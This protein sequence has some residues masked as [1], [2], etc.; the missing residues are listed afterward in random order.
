MDNN[1]NESIEVNEDNAPAVRPSA[2]SDALICIAAVLI[3]SFWSYE[4]YM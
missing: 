2:V 3:C 4:V 1:I